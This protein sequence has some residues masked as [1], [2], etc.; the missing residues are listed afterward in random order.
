VI[1]QPEPPTIKLCGLRGTDDAVA[2]VLAGADLLG[3][4]LVPGTRRYVPPPTATAMVRAIRETAV[5]AGRFTPEVVGV[6]GKMS[7]AVATQ[8]ATAIGVDAIQLVGSDEDC[9]A[10]ADVL[11]GGTPIIRTIAV[12]DAP[13]LDVLRE[14]VELWEARGARIVFDA[15]V[16]GELGG[17]GHRIAADSVRPLLAGGRRGL[18]GGLSPDNVAAVIRDLAPAMVDVSSGIE[19]H[20]GH[21]D[22]ELMRAFVAAVRAAH[23]DDLDLDS[24]AELDPPSLR[25]DHAG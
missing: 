21:K 24:L 23:I 8:L 6:V 2:A 4:V 7:L 18:A 15:Q 19:S 13:D 11:G 20:A 1:D 5:S 16:D 12:G 22:P 3:I 17:T 10:L 9:L 25:P 14:Q